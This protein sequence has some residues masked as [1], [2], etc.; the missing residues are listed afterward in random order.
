MCIVG[1]TKTGVW[2]V[3]LCRNL[4]ELQTGYNSPKGCD[5]PGFLFKFLFIF[6]FWPRW[7]SIAV[8]GLPLAVESRGYF[9]VA[10][11]GFLTAVASRVAV[12][13]L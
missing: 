9:P 1:H 13:G 8:H 10:V 7:A 4:T 6:Y 11:G 12:H 2:L 5:V 3:V